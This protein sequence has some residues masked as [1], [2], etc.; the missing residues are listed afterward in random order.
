MDL[1]NL[2]NCRDKRAPLI[3]LQDDSYV[4]NT[5]WLLFVLSL[6]V[7]PLNLGLTKSLLSLKPQWGFVQVE[8][9]IGSP[10]FI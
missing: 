8:L 9:L 5:V 2:L 4:K 7:V 1:P 10:F 3:P 6:G